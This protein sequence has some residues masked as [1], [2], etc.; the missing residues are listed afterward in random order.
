VYTT[1]TTWIYD[2]KPSHEFSNPPFHAKRC[3]VTSHSHLPISNQHEVISKKQIALHI[4]HFEHRLCCQRAYLFWD[5]IIKQKAWCYYMFTMRTYE[6]IADM[7]WRHEQDWSDTEVYMS[8]VARFYFRRCHD[9]FTVQG[10]T[11]Y[12]NS[13]GFL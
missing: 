6:D 9:R 4:Y 7:P 11:W 1:T 8:K 2:N 10:P 13:L 3:S 5:S 12:R